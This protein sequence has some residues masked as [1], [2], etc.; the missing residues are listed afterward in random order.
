MK[1]KPSPYS[2]PQLLDMAKEKHGLRSDRQLAIRLGLSFT[3]VTPYRTKG[4]I[5]D[6][7]TALRLAKLCGLEPAEVLLTCHLLR[8]KQVA[9]GKPVEKVYAD[10]LAMI[11][12]SAAAALLALSLMGSAPSPASAHAPMRQQEITAS[13]TLC[14]VMFLRHGSRDLRA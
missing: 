10:L 11:R 14:D 1:I 13:Y 2:I 4:V 3:A 8:A 7:L 5:P 12:K 9:E 6:D